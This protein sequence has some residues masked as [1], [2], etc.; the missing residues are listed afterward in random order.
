MPR[1]A[2]GSISAIPRWSI[3]CFT[4]VMAMAGWIHGP[5]V[6]WHGGRPN[7]ETPPASRSVDL[8]ILEPGD[9][10]HHTFTL[11]NTTASTVEILGVHT[12]C[13]CEQAAVRVG[14]CIEPG[15][16]ISIPYTL[17]RYGVG[18]RR[19][20]LTIET[21]SDHPDLKRIVYTLSASIPRRI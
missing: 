3:A 4:F 13:G 19:G 5:Q 17:S 1:L 18:V 11:S 6:R 10:A 15:E 12:S 8:G 9:D 2:L 16:S 7:T 20:T 21:S 14:E